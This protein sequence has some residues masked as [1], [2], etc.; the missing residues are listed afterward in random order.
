MES[1][2]VLVKDFMTAQPVRSEANYLL[3][4]GSYEGGVDPLPI[5]AVELGMCGLRWKVATAKNL[6]L[7]WNCVIHDVGTIKIQSA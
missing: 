4:F 7:M 2:I 3:P 1:F 5:G 6:Q